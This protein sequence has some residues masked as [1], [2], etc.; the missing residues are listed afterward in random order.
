MSPSWIPAAAAC[1]R[2][3]SCTSRLR[4]TTAVRWRSA[5]TACCTWAWATAA[6][7]A[8]PKATART[9]ASL[10][11]KILRLDVAKPHPRP[12]MYAYG[13][14]NPWRFS[15]DRGHRRPLDRR[16]RAEPLRG[17]R[18]PAGR[19][20]ARRKPGLERLR[21]PSGLQAPA[22]R[23]LAAGVAGRRL[24]AHRRL[25]DHRRLRLPRQRGAGAARPLRLRRLLQRP[26]LVAPG[27]R[28]RQP[29]LLALPRLEGLSSF[30]VGAHGE[31]YATT[32]GG[33]VLRFAPAP[34]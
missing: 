1:V 22:D 21:G 28:R 24:P 10:L 29:Q 27:R 4:T 13:L 15:F 12:Q 6:A 25:L 30:G 33:R 34:A 11:G 18:P 3:C 17:G 32:L 9:E 8:T 5:P 7:R 26:D 2:S 20:A 19:D 31:L 16:R 14:R 23:P